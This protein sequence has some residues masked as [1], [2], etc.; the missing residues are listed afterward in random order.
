M[1]ADCTLGQYLDH[2]WYSRDEICSSYGCDRPLR[3]HHRTYVH[4]E[5]CITV[6]I[7]SASALNK[8][9]TEA[10]ED[11]NNITTWSCCK[12][13][14]KDSLI[15]SISHNTWK[16]SFGKYL[17]LLFCSEHFRLNSQVSCPHRDNRDHVRYFAINDVKVRIHYDPIE[18]LEVI[19]PRQQITWEV[20]L[21]L[22]MKNEAFTRIE[23]RWDLYIISVKSRLQDIRYDTIL[24][25]KLEAC[26][27]EVDR[28]LQKAQEDSSNLVQKLQ[29]VYVS[30]KY[31]E[32]VPFNG[33]A[34]EMLELAG[35]WDDIFAKFEVEFLPDKDAR[36]L[37]DLQLRKTF[38]RLG[39]SA[40][41]N[42]LSTGDVSGK[43]TSQTVHDAN[44][45]SERP[46]ESSNPAVTNQPSGDLPDVST[47]QNEPRVS[48]SLSIVP[49][50]DSKQIQFLGAITSIDENTKYL[51][52]ED[53]TQTTEASTVSNPADNYE[54]D[55][56]YSP[57]T[58]PSVS[59]LPRKIA[60]EAI[61][62]SQDAHMVS[63]KHFHSR[64][65]AA[66]EAESRAEGLAK[67]H[68]S[69]SDR[70]PDI[71]AT[72]NSRKSAAQSGIP[73]PVPKTKNTRVSIPTN[74]FEQ[75]S[76]EFEHQRIEDRKKRA[77]KIRQRQPRS[78]LP[79]SSTKTIVEVYEDANEAIREFSYDKKV[80]ASNDFILAPNETTKLGS[81]PLQT[82]VVTL[83]DGGKNKE[84]FD[85]EI[86]AEPDVQSTATLHPAGDSL[87]KEEGNGDEGFSDIKPLLQDFFPGMEELAGSLK[88]GN[89]DIPKLQRSSLF[90]MLTSLWAKQSLN[91]WQPLK[92]PVNVTDHIFI[93]SDIIVRED[94][95][96]SLIAFTLNTEDYRTR[97][98]S[99]APQKEDLQVKDTNSSSS[100]TGKS[101]PPSALESI[102]Q[103]NNDSELE[104][105]LL[106]GT[107][108]HL[109]Y[110]F[111]SGSAKMLCK[112]FYVERFDA[113]RR[114]LGVADRI[115]ESLSRCLKWESQGGKSRSVFLKTL[116]NRFVLKS[117]SA[118][119]TADFLNFA[120]AYFDVVTESLFHELPSVIAKTVGFFQVSIKN[121]ATNTNV[122]LDL[123]IV[124][125]LFY[126]RSPS[127]IFDLKGSMRNRKIE[128][129]GQQNEVL[130]DENMID[131][132]SES[133]LFVREQS[134][135][136]LQQSIWNDTLFLAQQNVM[137]YSLMVAIDETKKELVVGIV[138]YI[139]TYTI[140]KR[141]ET[142]IKDR[143]FVGNK[144]RPTIMEP[145][146]YKSRFREAIKR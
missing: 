73:R 98:D 10:D 97:L 85:S 82:N 49:K 33:I 76:K 96:S 90:K 141:L 69:L 12:I 52:G 11:N 103:G 126:G 13:C 109:K 21:D 78:I 26:K 75:L 22:N 16:Y 108:S 57:L 119:E 142:W 87:K 93:D 35:L 1:D 29:G 59:Q 3:E 101:R 4:D 136:L 74:Q 51:G 79:R 47:A 15:N 86:S 129:T 61:Q 94:E 37:T 40:F 41:E 127:R 140:D 146:E 120:P 135:K 138:D 117:L 50:I 2:L 60:S 116:D 123:L 113:L 14:G 34:Q 68:K 99:L 91:G 24:P 128:S 30:S 32:V 83:S 81:A 36:L 39:L 143:A 137:D 23:N 145:K 88:S 63:G 130:L 25:E 106:E 133:P 77:E 131:F 122:K 45:Q 144:N 72:I 20:E 54:A 139:R 62:C 89:E 102:A 100:T 7:E 80:E 55:D 44:E 71:T 125:N 19:V 6:V 92:Y 95:P 104:K 121:P 111:T 84:R 118:I 53:R 46:R 67:V 110:E 132:I 38:T 48:E 65:G 8:E 5:S 114:K 43:P 70:T 105:N 107:N 112:V 56:Q 28:L 42:T 9:T 115:V 124:E 27:T 64:A 66:A 31:Y 17:E 18:L 58:V 134:K